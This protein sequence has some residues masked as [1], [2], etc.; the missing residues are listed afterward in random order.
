MKKIITYSSRVALT[1]LLFMAGFTKASAGATWV[2]KSAIN[3]NQTWYYCAENLGSWCSGGA[4]HNKDLGTI[5]SLAIGGQ[6]QVA[7]DN[8][9]WKSGT[10]VMHYKIDSGSWNDHNLSYVS[11]GHGEYGNNMLFQSGGGTFSSESIDLTGLKVGEHTISIYF[12]PLDGNY[13][14]NNSANYVAKFTIPDPQ[15]VTVSSAGYATYVSDYDLD[16][17]ST[18]YIKAYTATVNTTNAKVVLSPINKVAAKTPVILYAAGGAT[19]NI[20]VDLSSSLSPVVCD[21]VAGTDEDVESTEVIS[22]TTYCNYIL[23]NIGGVVGFYWANN[24][25]VASNRAYLHT[26]YNVS[27]YSNARMTIVFDD[28]VTSIKNLTPAFN[29]GEEAIYDLQGRRVT[30]PTKGLYIV[31]GKKVIK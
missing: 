26:T 8:G 5:T 18:T 2:G 9:D 28:E 31:N 7:S 10:L 11:Y 14:S 15:E 12:G 1:L 25:K 21:L 24:Q 27:A 22:E 4:F 17:T 16:F 3:V 23:N 19:E 29:E 30:Q 6:S 20:P 13:D